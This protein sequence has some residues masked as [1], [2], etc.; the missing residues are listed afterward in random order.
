MELRGATS[1]KLKSPLKATVTL[2]KRFYQTKALSV[3]KSIGDFACIC[4]LSSFAVKSALF[5]AVRE[6]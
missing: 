5:T 6:I 4:V 3:Q 2:K 1:V